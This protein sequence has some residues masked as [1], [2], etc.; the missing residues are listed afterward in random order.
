MTDEPE[1]LPE[2]LDIPPEEAPPIGGVFDGY[3]EV[4]LAKPP[5]DM[6][7]ADPDGAD[8]K[9]IKAFPNP[10]LEECPVVPLGHYDGRVVFAM[11]EGVIREEPAAKIGQLLRTDIF[12]S[13]A[14][15]AYMTY[16]RDAEDKFLRELAAIWFVRQCRDAG[17][18]DRNRVKRSLGVWPGPNGTVI[19]HRGSEVWTIGGGKKPTIQTVAETLR[20][21]SGPVYLLRPPAPRPEKPVASADMAW[22]RAHLD[23]WRFDPIGDDGLTGADVVMGYIGGGML[24]GFAPFRGHVMISAMQ[25]SGKSELMLFIQAVMSALAPPV[26]D[27]W[28]DAGLRS[29]LSGMARPALLDEAEAAASH[30]GEGPVEQALNLLRRMSTGEGAT[31]RQG[32]TG[33]ETV[34]Q[35]AVGAVVL[36]AINL[37]RLNAADA[38]RMVEVRLMPLSGSDLAA[39]Q[40]KPDLASPAALAEAL[41]KAREMAP[42]VLGRALAGGRRY[43]QDVATMKAAIMRKMRDPRAADLICMLAA[44]RRLLMS[45]APLAP[46]EADDEVH[47]WAPLMTARE[48]IDTVTNQGEEALAHLMSIGADIYRSDRR[49]T[50]GEIVQADV[51]EPRLHAEPLK[52]YGLRI[53]YGPAPDGR[54]GPWLFV[55][56]KHPALLKIF[57]K[58]RWP[59][60]RRSLGYLDALGP[61][62]RTWAAPPLYYGVGSKA[63][64]TAIPLAPWLQ[65]DL[66][67]FQGVPGH[68]SGHAVDFHE[69]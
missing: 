4:A 21:K 47:F 8:E 7:E 12:A 66:S 38:S 17:Y 32:S 53:E 26:I 29:D 42:G 24:G 55:S 60:W 36:A 22:I 56:N 41:S 31:R 16:W 54:P 39:D 5:T 13:A 18:Y 11:P 2:A 3:E 52:A 68:R 43:R 63:R 15:S 20:E 59:D 14:G 25:G 27:S 57:E 61:E 49:L 62:H 40:V 37:P 50:L 30:F 51:K 45:D 9:K 65:G 1:D 58:T 35:T 64:G 67:S 19:L 28:T 10:P 44:G 23:N 46:D 34:T 6:K 48:E 33:G 69:D